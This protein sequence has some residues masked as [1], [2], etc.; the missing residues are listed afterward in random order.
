MKIFRKF[1]IPAA[2]CKNIPHILNEIDKNLPSHWEKDEDAGKRYLITSLNIM[3]ISIMEHSIHYQLFSFSQIKVPSVLRISYQGQRNHQ[4]SVLLITM[5]CQKILLILFCL[6]K[7]NFLHQI[8]LI[9]I[10]IYRL[11][12]KNYSIAFHCQQIPELDIIIQLIKSVG[13]VFF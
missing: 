7:R 12:V 4:V 2:R 13:F 5:D 1:F 8:Q 3:H 11:K 6:R 10:T 9:S